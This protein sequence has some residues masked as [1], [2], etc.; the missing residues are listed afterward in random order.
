MMFDTKELMGF[1][2]LMMVGNDY[3]FSLDSR[4]IA[5]EQ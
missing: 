5:S 1:V 4:L 3:D 2:C